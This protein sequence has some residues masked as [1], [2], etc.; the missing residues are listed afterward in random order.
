MVG[1]FDT[2]LVVKCART[3]TSTGPREPQPVGLADPQSVTDF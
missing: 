3:T 1:L 2:F